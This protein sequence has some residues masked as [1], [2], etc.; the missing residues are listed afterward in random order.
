MTRLAFESP[1]V[2]ASSKAMFVANAPS[3]RSRAF[4]IARLV[5][6]PETASA[7]VVRTFRIGEENVLGN[8]DV[9]GEVFAE[10]GSSEPIVLDRLARASDRIVLEVVNVSSAAVRFEGWLEGTYV[11]ESGGVS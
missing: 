6:G 3:S 5:L 7:F 8:G 11:A 4:R 2:D 1:I 9:P 10:T